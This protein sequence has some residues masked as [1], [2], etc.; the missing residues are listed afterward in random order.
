MP[1]NEQTPVTIQ[2]TQADIDNSSI[3]GTTNSLATAIKRYADN[4]LLP[5]QELDENVQSCGNSVTISPRIMNGQ[6]VS[7]CEAFVCTR[8]YA[9][10]ATVTLIILLEMLGI[11]PSSPYTATLVHS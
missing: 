11:K 4:K 5:G 6:V 2:V 8:P 3:G 9:C 10:D 1:F 7:V